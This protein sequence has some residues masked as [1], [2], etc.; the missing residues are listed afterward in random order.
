MPAPVNQSQTVKVT[1]QQ[2][3]FTVVDLP[4]QFSGKLNT[5]I[6]KSVKLKIKYDYG[7]AGY[8]DLVR[9]LF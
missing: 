5:D 9:P 8:A 6:A 2:P 4:D 3:T 7:T 1:M